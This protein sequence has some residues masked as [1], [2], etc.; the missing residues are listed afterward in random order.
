MTEHFDFGQEWPAPGILLEDAGG[1]RDGVGQ[2]DLLFNMKCYEEGDATFTGKVKAAA[3]FEVAR[4]AL[5]MRPEFGTYNAS[6]E[7]AQQALWSAQG[8]RRIEVGVEGQSLQEP[9]AG[10]RGRE[11]VFGSFRARFKGV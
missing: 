8:I 3:L 1:I 4:T 11:F 6:D 7:A 9:T 10:R 5:T 2:V